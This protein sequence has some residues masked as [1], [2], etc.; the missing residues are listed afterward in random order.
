MFASYRKPESLNPISGDK[1][2]PL[3]RINALAALE[4][5]YRH[6][7]KSPKTASRAGNDRVF[8]GNRVYVFRGWRETVDRL[9]LFSH[10]ETGR[11]GV[12][13]IMRVV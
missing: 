7:K 10:F 8:I 5:Y 9:W 2:T 3:S 1:F 6:I 4:K 12:A 13:Y 11:H